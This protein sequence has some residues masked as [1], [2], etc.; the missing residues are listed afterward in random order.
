MTV[1]YKNHGSKSISEACSKLIFT[2][3]SGNICLKPAAATNIKYHLN[4]IKLEGAVSF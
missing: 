1:H 2:S 3:R 4:Q